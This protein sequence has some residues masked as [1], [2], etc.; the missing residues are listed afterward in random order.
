MIAQELDPA[1][2]AW[3]AVNPEDALMPL[4]LETPLGVFSAER[5]GVGRIE[6]RDGELRVD[7]LGELG[8]LRVPEGV[9]VRR[10]GG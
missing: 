5:C 1:S 4:R 7:T 6:P 3:I 8:G 9:A 2:R 10:E